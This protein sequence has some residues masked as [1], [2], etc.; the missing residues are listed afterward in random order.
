MKI[1]D[2]QTSAYFGEVS[3][4]SVGYNMN[5]LYQISTFSGQAMTFSD[6]VMHFARQVS[7]FAVHA[8]KF[9]NIDSL[10]VCVANQ[11]SR[12]VTSCIEY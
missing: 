6:H 9:E 7:T 11:D 2:G 4:Y 10:S 12:T 5:S 3:I 1:F 8:I